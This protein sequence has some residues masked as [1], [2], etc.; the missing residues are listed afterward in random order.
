MDQSWGI[1]FKGRSTTSQY[2]RKSIVQ[3]TFYTKTTIPGMNQLY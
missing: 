3:D 2:G 1:D